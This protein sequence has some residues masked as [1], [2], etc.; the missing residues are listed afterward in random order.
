MNDT[1]QEDAERFAEFILAHYPPA[2][3]WDDPVSY[4]A[5]HIGHA[6]IAAVTDDDHEI[7]AIASARPV[8]RPGMGVLPAYFNE[9]GECLHIDL[10]I[11]TT[12]DRRAVLCLREMA[13]RRFPHCKVAAM[14]RHFE[15]NIKVY[16][17]EKLY[18]SLEKIPKE[19]HEAVAA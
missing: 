7:V 3:T 18:R 19:K 6:F 16:P 10:L 9:W 1:L 8:D 14:F 2:R 17:I 11:D 5:W 12:D 13:K 15:G 4:C